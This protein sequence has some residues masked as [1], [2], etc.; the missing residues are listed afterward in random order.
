MRDPG[1]F[2]SVL[3]SQIH[4][5]NDFRK[6]SILPQMAKITEKI[7]L[8]LN[9]SDLQV[10]NN[11]HAF[12][13]GRSTVS[14]LI[15]ITQKWYDATDNSLSGRK[16]VHA[17]DCTEAQLVEEGMS[18]SMQV[19]ID[20]ICKWAETNKMELNPQKTK[21]MWICFTDSVQEPPPIQIGDEIIERVK[22]FKLLGVCCQNNLKWNEHIEQIT[23]KANR[24]HFTSGN[25]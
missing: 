2:I 21:D 9:G 7:Q 18:S 8:Q 16:G 3:M 4:I 5:K 1:L 14:A 6:I 12:I 19:A 13:Q 23:R 10:K 22:T 25:A 24:K 11:Q 15:S 17:D 20:C